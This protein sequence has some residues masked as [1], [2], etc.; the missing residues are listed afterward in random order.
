M[1]NVYM[2]NALKKQNDEIRRM[3]GYNSDG[4]RAKTET[5]GKDQNLSMGDL[6]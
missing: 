2:S 3:L 5:S 1:G 4:F 6:N